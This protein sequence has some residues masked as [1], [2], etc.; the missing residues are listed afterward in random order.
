MAESPLYSIV[1]RQLPTDPRLVGGPDARRVDQSVLT[2]LGTSVAMF[3][4]ILALLVAASYP[5]A[6]AETVLGGLFLGSVV[7]GARRYRRYGS[8]SREGC[9]AAGTATTASRGD[10]AC[11]GETA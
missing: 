7:I 4:A 1:M 3:L 10:D 5:V 9:E 8:E 11:R 2:V 6:A